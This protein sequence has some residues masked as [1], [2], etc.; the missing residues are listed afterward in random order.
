MKARI[1]AALLIL[2][3]SAQAQ[4]PKQILAKVNQKFAK[5]NDYSANIHLSFELPSINM[6]P[7]DGKVFFKKPTKFRIRTKGIIFLPKQNPYY[8]LSTLADTNAYTA[9]SSGE[10]KIG[11]TAAEII[12]VIPNGGDGDLILGKFWID[13]ANSVVLRSQLTTKSSGTILIDN[14]YGPAS[15][16]AYALPDKMIITVDM[17]KFKVPKMISA[18]INSKSTH[19]ANESKKGTGVIKLSY[20]AYAINQKL[21]D[22]VFTEEAK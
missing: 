3:V 12:Q 8:S 9:I 19:T 4:S 16:M 2:S 13:R 7:I 6:E 18:D 15:S 22:S 20:S 11:G 10:E 14:L 5:V 1:I 21:P 17:A